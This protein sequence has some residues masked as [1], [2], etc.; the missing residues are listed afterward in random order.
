MGNGKFSKIIWQ[1]LFFVIAVS[2]TIAFIPREKQF[3]YHF[4]EGKP[5]R[6]G[7]LTAPFDFPVYKRDQE[8]TNEYNA[9]TKSFIPFFVTDKERETNEI[10]DFRANNTSNDPDTSLL[11]KEVEHLLKMVYKQG[12]V[13]LKIY[14]ELKSEQKDII[15]IKNGSIASEYST[16]NL[17]TPRMAYEL[18]IRNSHSAELKDIISHKNLNLYIEPNLLYDTATNK[19]TLDQILQNIQPTA[20]MVQKGERIIDRG[21]IVTH[22]LYRILNSYEKKSLKT[23]SEFDKSTYILAGKILMVIIIYTFL[24]LFLILFRFRKQ[25]FFRSTEYR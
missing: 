21:V 1:S 12:I 22:D 18:M 16:T 8:L 14:E 6:Y 19:K 7:L 13:D 11:Y 17:L 24:Y 25:S 23:E 4:E 9:A 5:W 10:A 15:R 3:R 2:L 20:G